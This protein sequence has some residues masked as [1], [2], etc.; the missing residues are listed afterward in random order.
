MEM[1]VALKRLQSVQVNLIKFIIKTY[2]LY[3]KN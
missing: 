1:E 2:F 3:S